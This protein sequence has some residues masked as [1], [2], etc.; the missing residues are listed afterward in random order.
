MDVKDGSLFAV[1]LA[2]YSMG[3]EKPLPKCCVSDN[4]TAM[5]TNYSLMFL[6]Q[7]LL[8]PINKLNVFLEV[9]QSADTDVTKL[10]ICEGSLL[11]TKLPPSLALSH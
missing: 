4:L 3:Y 7:P 11:H 1:S 5:C 8:F 6:N 9:I 10:W 2:A